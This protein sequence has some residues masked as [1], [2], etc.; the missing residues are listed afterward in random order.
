MNVGDDAGV[1]YETGWVASD[2]SNI[3]PTN[4][5]LTCPGSSAWTA[6]PGSSEGLPIDCVNWWE[7]YAFCIWDG[8]FLP[9]EPEWE[10]AASGGSQQREY[11]WGAT[12]PGTSSQYAIYGCYYPNGSGT[13]NGVASLA[14]VGT[15][16]EGAGLWGQ[17]DLAGNVYEWNL[18]WFSTYVDP[19]ADCANLTT[20][21]GAR[22][23]RGGDCTYNATNVLSWFRASYP[24]SNRSN[25]VGLR[26]ART[27]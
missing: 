16:A 13:C 2:N 19:C 24:P 21:S 11:P 7:A 8:G 9:S 20:G 5:N 15:A 25:G 10:Y 23:M 18:D 6:A 3:A 26:C 17:L 27:P 14:P 22:V 4:A 1:A 12:A